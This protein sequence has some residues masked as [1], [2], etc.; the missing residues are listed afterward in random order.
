MASKRARFS[1]EYVNGWPG[2]VSTRA[3]KNNMRC[4]AAGQR[5]VLVE[6]AHSAQIAFAFFANVSENGEG[7]G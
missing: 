3:V 1:W 6:V 4:D 5:V 2:S 7:N